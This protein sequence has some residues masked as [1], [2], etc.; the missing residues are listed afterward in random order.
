MTI[1][2]AFRFSL[3]DLRSSWRK[4]LFV[5]LAVAAGTGALTGVRGFSE[6]FGSLLFREART[7]IASDL[8][9]RIFAQPNQVQNAAIDA[10]ARKGVRYTRVTETVSMA[11][12]PG[13]S[14]PALVTLKAVDPAVFPFYGVVE[15]TPAMTL[16]QALA[17]N[18]AAVSEDL[19]LRLGVRQGQMLRLGRQEFRINAVLTSEPDRMSGAFS[20]GPRVLISRDSLASTGLIG[21]GSRASQRLLF[22]AGSH[23]VTWVEAELKKAF[24]EALIVNYRDMN[25]NV[26]RGISRTSTFLSLIS[27]IALIIGAIGVAAAMHAHLQTRMDS[28]AIVKSLGGSS[29]S[30]LAIYGLQTAVL[31]IAG[32]LLGVV[33]G[34]AVQ[35]AL[36]QLLGKLLPMRPALVFSPVVALQGLALGVL[37]TALFTWPALLGVREIRPAL[38]F[39]RAMA[40]TRPHWRARLR[41]SFR[42]VLTG[43]A[44]CLG[45]ALVS[46]T[47]VAG[48]PAEA[49]RV[50]AAF[51]GGLL[52][53][54]LAVALLAWLLTTA[55]RQVGS[56]APGLPIVLKHAFANL[57]RPGS[58]SRAVLTSL[59]IGVMFT[60]TVW[61]MQANVLDAIRRSS[62]PDMANVFLIDISESDREP[63]MQLVEAQ[64]GIERR[65]ELVGA[66]SC[67]LEAVNGVLADDLGLAGGAARRYRMAR[68]ISAEPAK[69][70]GTH[71]VQGGWWTADDPAPQISVTQSAARALRLNIGSTLR[72]NASGKLIETRVA[73]IHRTDQ[74]RLRGMMEFHMN[75]EAVAGLPVVY[76]ASARVKSDAIGPLQRKVFSN[77]PSVT[78]I[79][80]AD[81]LDRV[82]QVVDQIS[83]IIRFLSGFAI[84]AGAIILASSVAGT[85]FRRI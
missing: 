65:L 16:R 76:Y 85:R 84:F 78:V 80:V 58:Q 12:A 79:N 83:V 82:Q 8:F 43:A 20:V 77:F 55:L 47:L 27:L 62:P 44:V 17:G 24:P 72:W 67:R 66:V 54:L 68:N 45:L 81:I 36:P 40:D 21:F 71:V 59:G 9:V 49:L 29:G 25:P 60:L 23:P 42:A 37:T 13:A 61:L 70:A 31:G 14:D 4:F 10:L 75:S 50:G 26:S 7:L 64:S 33:L 30:V 15:L 1:R 51:V 39:R 63:L 22:Q 2:S 28:I 69:P 56:R 35:A 73:A 11:G 46:A 41:Q 57:H 48:P 34:M 74:Q 5:I 6:S 52:V 19:L 18:G 32:G 38:I 53:S 3:R